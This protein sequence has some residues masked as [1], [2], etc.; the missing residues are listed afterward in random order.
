MSKKKEEAPPEPVKK[1]KGDPEPTR[2]QKIEALRGKVNSMFKSEVLVSADQF[3]NVY[4]I[5]RPTGITRLDIALAGGFPA[6][7]LSELIG[8]DSSTKTWLAN[9]VIANLQRNYGAD[10]AISLAMTETRYDKAFAKYKC[11][12][13]I[14]YSEEEIGLG[15]QAN[16]R[17][18]TKEELAFLRDQV[19]II[20]MPLAPNAEMLLEIVAQQVESGLY[21]LIVIDS[22]GAL[23]T[24]AEANSE[25][26][27]TDAHYAGAAKPVTSFMH[28]LHRAFVMAGPDGKPNT[29]T[30]LAINQYRDKIG[31]KPWQNPMN[32][33]GGNALK[34][35]KLVDVLLTSGGHT[36]V[37]IGKQ[38]AIVGKEIYWEVIKGKAGV[39]DGPK[40]SYQFYFGENGYP[41]GADIYEDLLIAGVETG[42]VEQAGAWFARNGERLGQGK[43][44]ASRFLYEHTDILEAIR[45]DIFDKSRLSFI[46]KE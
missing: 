7:G 42:V 34:H 11:G 15:E 25:G 35:G 39:H 8:K 21:Q 19:G 24:D 20:D 36:K 44:N 40:G 45:K 18:Y 3:P 29:T 12:V 37:T 23:M 26:G 31:A 17:P 4:I 28:R 46:V 38:T 10:S 9:Q 16:K 5:R 14:A 33:A 13:R 6:G 32:I 30:V 43:E 1:K 41:F 27:I 22:L 2:S